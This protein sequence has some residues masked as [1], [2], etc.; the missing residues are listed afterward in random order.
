M[1]TFMKHAVLSASVLGLTC[2]AAFADYTLNILHINDL[3]SRIESINKYDSTCSTEDEGEGKC[4]G[5]IA[6]VK[7]KIDERRDSL[8]GEG[9]NVLVLDAGDQFQGS[10]F[11]ST[12]KG[13][14]AAEFMNGIGFDAMAVGNHEFDD[15]PE[16]LRDFIDMVEFPVISGNTISGAN[17][18]LGDRVKPYIIKEVGGEK[19]ALMSVLAADTVETSSPGPSVL[20]L[21]EIEYLKGAVSQI[22]EDEGVNKIVLVS[23]VGLPKDEAIA[24]AVDG[25]DVIVGG[26]SHTL[27]SNTDEN[28]A[29]PYPT[30]VTNPSGVAVPI[31]QA[32]AYSKYVGE[33]Q[34]T[35]DDEGKVIS[36]QGDPH[37]L[38]ASVPPDEAFAARVTELGAPI[39]ELKTKIVSESTDVIEGSRDVCRAG[40][41]SMGNLVADAM[42][43]RTAS[44]GVSIVIQN[45]GGLRSSIDAERDHHGRSAHRAAVPEHAC[46][47]RPQGIGR[48]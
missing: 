32:Y 28:A 44:Q 15:G 43:D 18:V 33:I 10:L 31:V 9:A 35:F 45:G 30:M 42:L 29:S 25:I 36:A 16:G 20:I 3:H 37:L 17:S 27:L 4:F 38:D 6:R 26:H 24:A 5:G 21:D 34:V 41:C 7:T 22:E 8:T 23:H 19:I 39:E 12:Y 2:G 11:Y 14:A 46:D 1:S 13:K 48:D 40:E 47:I